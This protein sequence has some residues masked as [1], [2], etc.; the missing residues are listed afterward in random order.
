V[1]RSPEVIHVVHNVR[2]LEE[3]QPFGLGGTTIIGGAA[4]WD[5]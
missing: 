3:S 4:G 5:E 1:S 2:L